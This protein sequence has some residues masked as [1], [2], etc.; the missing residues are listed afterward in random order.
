[1]IKLPF[2]NSSMDAMRRIDKMA[3]GSV[4]ACVKML[5]RLK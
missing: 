2:F 5:R 4:E 3:K 1:M